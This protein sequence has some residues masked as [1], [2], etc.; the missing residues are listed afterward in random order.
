ME[1]NMRKQIENNEKELD[2]LR[3]SYEEKLAEAQK[4]VIFQLISSE[5]NIFI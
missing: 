2:S 4:Q 5:K 3:K 1:E